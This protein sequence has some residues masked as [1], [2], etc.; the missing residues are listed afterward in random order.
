MDDSQYSAIEFL[1]EFAWASGASKDVVNDAK[2]E[3]EKLKEKFKNN[4]Q[5]NE[6]PSL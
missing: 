3:L 6:Q 1:I 5:K 4:E 2:K